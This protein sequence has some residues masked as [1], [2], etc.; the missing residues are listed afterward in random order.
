MRWT[1]AEPREALDPDL[2]EA[3]RRLEYGSC[4]NG[5]AEPGSCVAGPGNDAAGPGNDAAGPGDDAAGPG[6]AA[7]HDDGAQPA[8]H[9]LAARSW[10]YPLERQR[11]VYQLCRARKVTVL[12]EFI[13]KASLL[14]QAETVDAAGVAELLG[15]DPVFVEHAA[16]ALAGRGLLDG[17]ALPAIRFTAAGRTAL[18]QGQIVETGTNE[19]LEFCFDRKFGTLYALVEPSGTDERCP[20]WPLLD[21]TVPNLKEYVNRAFVIRAGQTV[22]RAIEQPGSGQSVSAIVSATVV[23]PVR[24]RMSELWTWDAQSGHIGCHVWDHARQ[25]FHEDLSAFI[26]KTPGAADLQIRKDAE[27]GVPDVRWRS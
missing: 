16:A 19:T 22:G 2:Q 4:G 20:V 7:G 23:E 3:L 24:T 27:G 5:S 9:V 11:V 21:K 12:E 8:V 6:D 10:Q 17:K 14:P 26:R 25:A 18:E 13:Y 1:L 15:L